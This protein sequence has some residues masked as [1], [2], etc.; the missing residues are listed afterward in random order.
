MYLDNIILG[1]WIE[2]KLVC[3]QIWPPHSLN[4]FFFLSLNSNLRSNCNLTPL[5]L[6]NGPSLETLNSHTPLLVTYAFIL[7]LTLNASNAVMRFYIQNVQS[8]NLQQNWTFQSVLKVCLFIG[9][10]GFERLVIHNK[11]NCIKGFFSV[12]VQLDYKLFEKESIIFF[13]SI[14]G[15]LCL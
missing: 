7:R 2:K 1:V 8:V 10:I 15:P 6:L 13:T 3:K 9:V 12:Q 14:F 4:F 11:I 5:I